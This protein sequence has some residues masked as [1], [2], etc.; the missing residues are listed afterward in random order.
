[1]ILFRYELEGGGSA[2]AYLTERNNH[3]SDDSAEVRIPASYITDA[4]RVLADA[5]ER[6]FA[7][8]SSSIRKGTGCFHQRTFCFQ[9][10]L[11]SS[12]SCLK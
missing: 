9:A 2:D 12:T 7:E 11:R 5:V 10:I 4:P 1:M 8:N 3:L 6:L